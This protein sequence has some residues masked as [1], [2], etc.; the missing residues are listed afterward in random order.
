MRFKLKLITTYGLLLKYCERNISFIY[1]QN[2]DT[3]LN[4]ILNAMWW[5]SYDVAYL[6]FN[7]LNKILI[8]SIISSPC[9]SCG[10]NDRC[11]TLSM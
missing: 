3:T 1:W 5:G 7:N 2:P 10:G 9:G 6:F 4:E 8:S 11:A